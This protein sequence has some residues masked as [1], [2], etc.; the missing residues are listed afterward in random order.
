MHRASSAVNRSILSLLGASQLPQLFL[1]QQQQQQREHIKRMMLR[2][3]L[4]GA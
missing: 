3:L 1:Q 2:Q 4:A